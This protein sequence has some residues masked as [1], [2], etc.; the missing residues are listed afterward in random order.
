MFLLSVDKVVDEPDHH[1]YGGARGGQA[2]PGQPLDEGGHQ[3][4]R[5]VARAEKNVGQVKKPR[6]VFDMK[7]LRGEEMI[8]LGVELWILEVVFRDEGEHP[9]EGE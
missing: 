1:G 3:V 6:L 5:E 2:E 9:R 7:Q 4:G 8:E